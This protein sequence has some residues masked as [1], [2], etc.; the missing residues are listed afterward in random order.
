MKYLIFILAVVV[1]F[2]LLLAGY[3]TFVV[4]LVKPYGFLPLMLSSLV[5]G[6]PS[7]VFV[8]RFYTHLRSKYP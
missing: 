8:D 4:P 3:A 2:V 1:P 6:L 5:I 7:G